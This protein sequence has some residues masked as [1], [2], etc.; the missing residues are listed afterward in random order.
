M[1]G[2]VTGCHS[3]PVA[4]NFSPDFYVTCA[5]V[6]PVFFLA[7]AVQGRAYESVLRAIWRRSPWV[8]GL[9]LQWIALPIF[10]AGGSG[11]YYAL[12]ALYKGSDQHRAWV[13]QATL[14]LLA[15]VLVAPLLTVVSAGRHSPKAASGE[16][17]AAED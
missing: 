13:F 11:E 2:R 14:I 1:Q 15:A 9:Y 7:V 10:F 8:T 12:L 4:K 5:T 16:D 17:E 6:I 3:G